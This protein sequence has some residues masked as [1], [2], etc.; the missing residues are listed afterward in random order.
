MTE[1]VHV[2]GQ[3]F[4][5]AHMEHYVWCIHCKKKWS[6]S[7][8]EDAINATDR[9]SAEDAVTGGRIIRATGNDNLADA[10]QSYAD[11]LEGNDDR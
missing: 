10:N 6:K 2:L 1:C 7:E 9:L 4:N 5:I 3:G 8:V 11:A